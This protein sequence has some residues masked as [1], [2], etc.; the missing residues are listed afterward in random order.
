MNSS[1]KFLLDESLIKP[2]KHTCERTWLNFMLKGYVATANSCK[3][4]IKRRNILSNNQ[5]VY[6]DYY[7]TSCSFIIIIFLVLIIAISILYYMLNFQNDEKENLP[8]P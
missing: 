4:Q 8:R 3:S 1:C 6:F 2:L 5:N 7:N